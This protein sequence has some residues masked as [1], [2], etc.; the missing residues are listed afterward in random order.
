MNTPLF[1]VL[2]AG[3]AAASMVALGLTTEHGALVRVLKE[4][5]FLLRCLLASVVVVP[6]IGALVVRWSTIAPATRAG[7]LLMTL[8]PGG[9]LGLQFTKK[10][11]APS[12]ALATQFILSVVGLVVT[13][14]LATHLLRLETPLHL[15]FPA[16]LVL[17]VTLLAA[18]LLLGRWLQRRFP[19]AAHRAAKALGLAGTLCFVAAFLV[20]AAP[21]KREAKHIVGPE[22]IG[23]MVLIVALSMMVGWL[24]GGADPTARQVSMT[25]ASVRNAALALV[26]AHQGFASPLVAQSVMAY[27][28]LMVPMNFV[29]TLAMKLVRRWAA[30]APSTTTE[31]TRA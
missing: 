3:F 2:M 20:M 5:G 7:I 10:A 28:A 17:V 31:R 23:A 6:L 29:M 12:Y 15:E 1:Y 22:A 30:H 25:K 21:L 4:R 18:P 8:A 13:P 26:V 16:R 9:I 14:F 19:A 11:D 24:L 27:A